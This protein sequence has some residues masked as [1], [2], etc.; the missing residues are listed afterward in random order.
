VSDAEGSN[1]MPVSAH[2]AHC[3]AQALYGGVEYEESSGTD[4]SHDSH[5]FSAWR[6]PEKSVQRGTSASVKT[7]GSMTASSA[8]T[9]ERQ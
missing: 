5:A 9:E 8:S 1:A 6:L 3:D 7:I 2:A 4:N